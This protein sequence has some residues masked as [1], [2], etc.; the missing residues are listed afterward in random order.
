MSSSSLSFDKLPLAVFCIGQDKKI[1]SWNSEMEVLTGIPREKAI[2]SSYK[3]VKFQVSDV[4]N[5][6]M[7]VFK[8]IDISK[9]GDGRRNIFI[10]DASGTLRQMYAQ[11]RV[12]EKPFS[13]VFTLSDISFSTLCT[14]I[15]P[16]GSGIT[17]YHGLVGKDNLMLQLYERI[18]KAAASPHVTT[19]ITGESGTGKEL[20][21]R[22]IHDLSDRKAQPFIAVHCAALPETLLESELFGHVKGSFTG[23]YKDMQGKFEQASGGTIF[24]DEIGEI[25]PLIQIKLLRVLQERSLQRIGGSKE[26]P[27]DIRIIAATNRNIKELVR[28]GEF[29][30][31]LFYRLHVFPVET[32]PLRLHKNDLPLL[33]SHFIRKFNALTGKK[34][35]T[36]SQ[37]SM[38]LLMEYPFPGNIRELENAIEHAFVLCTGP[39]IRVEDLPA[40]IRSQIDIKPISEIYGVENIRTRSRNTVTKERLAEILK[41]VNYNRSETARLLGI[42]RVA[43]WQKMKKMGL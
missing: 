9:P 35:A 25:S 2:Q 1:T 43:L 6:P 16:T 7:D 33:V 30:E 18:N 8:C 26:I 39:E 34:I 4:D 28:K 5:V 20:V 19:L 27:V 36:V 11:I 17:I 13:V 42:S 12:F 32:P 23:A 37:D 29:R 15:E 10:H 40:E 21:A 41:S 38:R 22:A 3:F 14:M 31:D 24:L